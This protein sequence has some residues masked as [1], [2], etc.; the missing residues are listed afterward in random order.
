MA[1]LE[2]PGSY[3]SQNPLGFSSP[4][5]KRLHIAFLPKNPFL[6]AGVWDQKE[7]AEDSEGLGVPVGA[8]LAPKHDI[9]AG[10][11]ACP[12]LQLARCQ[13]PP[14]PEQP[15]CSQPAR[16]GYVPGLRS[17]GRFGVPPPGCALGP[18]R[19]TNAA[20]WPL[21]GHKVNVYSM[22]GGPC[23]DVAVNLC[24]LG[25]PDLRVCACPICDV[26]LT[27]AAERKQGEMKRGFSP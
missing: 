3:R 4:R 5:G 8:S 1:L 19:S 26:S 2:Q 14:G 7:W 23:P 21:A 11:P 24:C 16:Y 18:L 27:E 13:E 25:S 10:N 12:W 22:R 17:G 6:C 9:S 20:P 15:S